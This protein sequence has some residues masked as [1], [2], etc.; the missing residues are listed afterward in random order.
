MNISPYLIALA[1]AW[2]I[3]HI[4]KYAIDA[5]RGK[6]LDFTHR[7]FNSGGMPSSHAATAVAVWSVVLFKDEVSSGLFGLATLI[8]LIICYD[9]V[10][11][12]R[13]VGE[14]GRAIQQIIE[15]QNLKITLPRAARGHTPVEV[16]AGSML[17]FLVGIVVFIA[18]V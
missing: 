15:K 2:I 6:Q 4:I 12:R 17:G 13:S 7:L 18:T 9:A 8:T 3:A 5:P 10:K 1:A 16:L 14:Q 11:V